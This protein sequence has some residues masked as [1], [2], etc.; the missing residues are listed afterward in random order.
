MTRLLLAALEF[1]LLP[2]NV[3]APDESIH[4]RRVVVDERHWQ[5]WLS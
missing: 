3:G 1:F 2:L 5:R 4:G